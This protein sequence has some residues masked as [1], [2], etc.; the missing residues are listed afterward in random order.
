MKLTEN[1]IG[2]LGFVNDQKIEDCFFKSLEV[3]NKNSEDSKKITI[4]VWFKGDSWTYNHVTIKEEVFSRNVL[5]DT[6]E[7]TVLENISRLKP[8]VKLLL[9]IEKYN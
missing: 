6:N 8:L 2:I 7:I 1:N 4:N 5:T 3:I 9:L